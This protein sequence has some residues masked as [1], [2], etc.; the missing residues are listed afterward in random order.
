VK[1]ELVILL[2]PTVVKGDQT[3]SSE[4]AAVQSRMERMQ[5]PAPATTPK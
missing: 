5:A 1:R 4:I 2:K 3:W